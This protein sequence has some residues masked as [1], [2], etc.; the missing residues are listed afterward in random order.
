MNF[1]KKCLWYLVIRSRQVPSRI[2]ERNYLGLTLAP[3]LS[4]IH[5][6]PLVSWYCPA[7][8]LIL[9]HHDLKLLR[10]TIFADPFF[11]S[12]A[13][14]LSFLVRSIQHTSLHSYSTSLLSSFF[15]YLHLFQPS[16]TSLT[17]PFFCHS[18]CN[19]FLLY[20]ATFDTSY[21]PLIAPW[22]SVFT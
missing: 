17:E 8:P 9:L 16:I 5:P 2:V 4:L 22:L 11:S 18:L 15:K 14:L 7:L 12:C 1:G 3:L 20:I 19:S 6:P 10:L 21:S 13:S